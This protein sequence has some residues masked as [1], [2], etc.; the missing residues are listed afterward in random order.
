LFENF[1]KVK[2]F[3]KI[4]KISKTVSK[5]GKKLQKF[6]KKNENIFKKLYLS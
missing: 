4:S 5:N 6:S 3:Q 2:P 1:K